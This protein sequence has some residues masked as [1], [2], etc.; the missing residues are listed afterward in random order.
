MTAKYINDDLLECMKKHH[1][2]LQH[3]IISAQTALDTYKGEVSR[4]LMVLDD[5]LANGDNF[6]VFEAFGAATSRIASSMQ[7]AEERLIEAGAHASLA[8]QHYL[9]FNEQTEGTND[10]N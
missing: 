2:V 8:L 4:R 9:N 7:A 3:A 6:A 5:Q 10:E 1:A